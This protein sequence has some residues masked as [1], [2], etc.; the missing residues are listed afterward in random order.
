MKQ[1]AE[2]SK[3]VVISKVQGQ[4]IANV[5]KSHLE[6]EG[7]PVFL[8]YESAGPIYGITMD[9]IGAVKILVPEELAEV[10]KQIIEPREVEE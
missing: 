8:Q 2:K 7:I 1:V 3:F 9:G 6:D 10:A 5:I 4:L